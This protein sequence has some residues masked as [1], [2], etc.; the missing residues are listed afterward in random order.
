MYKYINIYLYVYLY[1]YVQQ[2]MTIIQTPHLTSCVG[3]HMDGEHILPWIFSVAVDLMMM[4]FTYLNDK[5]GC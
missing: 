4:L 5:R 2:I 3:L 1:V